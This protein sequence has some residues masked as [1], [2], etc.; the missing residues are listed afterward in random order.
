[1]PLEERDDLLAQDASRGQFVHQDQRTAGLGVDAAAVEGCLGEL[2]HAPAA[3][4]LIQEEAWINV[5]TRAAGRVTL[6]AHRQ[7]TFAFDEARKE[8]V[9]C[10]GACES[11]LLIV[12][13]RHVVTIVNTL[14]DVTMSSA[15]CSH[16]PAY[17]RI[18]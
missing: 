4:V 1:V 5:E 8:P 12:R 11:F 14:S 17:S 3:L 16:V 9:G 15:G 13:T 18:L 2:E 10:F 6:D 7:R